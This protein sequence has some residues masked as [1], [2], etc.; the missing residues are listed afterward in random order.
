MPVIHASHPSMKSDI[1]CEKSDLFLLSVFDMNCAVFHYLWVI[2]YL[3]DH[4]ARQPLGYHF[5]Y[6]LRFKPGTSFSQSGHSTT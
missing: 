1:D 3:N 5:E 6:L 2:L 4:Q